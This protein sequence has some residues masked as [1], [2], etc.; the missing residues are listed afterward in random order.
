MAPRSVG[1]GQAVSLLL[2]VPLTGINRGSDPRWAWKLRRSLSDIFRDLGRFAPLIDL[3]VAC[4][5]CKGM[6]PQTLARLAPKRFRSRIVGNLYERPAPQDIDLATRI[7]YWVDRTYGA[8]SPSWL[9][10]APPDHA[11]TGD[12]GS[13]TIVLP[14]PLE[15]ASTAEALQGRLARYYWAEEWWGDGEAPGPGDVRLA[16][17]LMFRL[18]IQ[19]PAWPQVLGNTRAEFQERLELIRDLYAASQMRQRRDG[20]YPNWI[21]LPVREFGMMRPVELLVRGPLRITEVVQYAWTSQK[22]R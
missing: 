16:H 11:D 2:I 19:R 5:D 15:D 18:G 7:R 9:L 21:H 10:V 22:R 8:R 6:S 12:E 4:P 13:R 3:V 1:D 17:T 20:W 14:G